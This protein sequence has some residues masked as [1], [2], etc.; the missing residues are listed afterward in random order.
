MS[1]KP[2]EKLK[3][4]GP[5]S[6]DNSELIAIILGHGSKKENVFSLSKRIL[7]D[8]GSSPLISLKN[9]EDCKNLYDIGNVHASKLIA[10]F[11]LGRRFYSN[12]NQGRKIKNANEVFEYLQSMTKLKKEYMYGLYLNSRNDIIHEE[13]LSIG[14]LEST[15]IY[16]R[17]IFYPAII[18]HAYAVIL[19]HNHPSE[20]AHPSTEDIYMTEEIQKAAELLGISLLDHVIVCKDSFFSFT[21]NEICAL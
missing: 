7:K 21:E 1:F 3:L 15:H 12:K 11:E 6:L 9:I 16:I 20:D 18:H 5:D 2:R 10:S 17:D 8:Y 13:V 19:V 14:T 4:F